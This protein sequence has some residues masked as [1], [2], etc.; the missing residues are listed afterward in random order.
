MAARRPSPLVD[1]PVMGVA[2]QHE[3]VEVCPASPG[4]VHQ[5]MGLQPLLASAPREPTGLIAVAKHPSDLPTHH[6]PASSQS[7]RT[8][9]GLEHPLHP[10]V[11][12]QPADRLRAEAL[13]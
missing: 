3:V 11:A 7:N 8:A 9:I 13:P 2:Q 12:R 4:P 6:P 1:E 5:V 10:C